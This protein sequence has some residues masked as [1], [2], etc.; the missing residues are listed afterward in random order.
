MVYITYNGY[1]KIYGESTMEKFEVE[2]YTKENGEKP[3][4]EFILGLDTKMR[5]KILGIIDV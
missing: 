5:A 3:V 1:R 4:K 2:F